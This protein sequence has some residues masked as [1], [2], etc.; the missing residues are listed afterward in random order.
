M[1]IPR[2]R[3]T[4]DSVIAYAI[5]DFAYA[6]KNAAEASDDEDHIATLTYVM[7][8]NEI[9]LTALGTLAFKGNKDITENTNIDIN[10]PIILRAQTAMQLCINQLP[11][12]ELTGGS[13][14]DITENLH[15]RV[16]TC[17]KYWFA[18]FE[19]TMATI[20]PH[21]THTPSVYSPVRP[22]A[23]QHTANIIRELPREL[24]GIAEATL[25]WPFR[26]SMCPENETPSAK[27]HMGFTYHCT[28]ETA[29]ANARIT[30]VAATYGTYNT[31]AAIFEDAIGRDEFDSMDRIIGFISHG[32]CMMCNTKH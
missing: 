13:Q 19:D 29:K 4:H 16:D 27:F 3:I 21:M 2:P 23:H 22:I 25:S 30:A 31:K 14:S 7:Q 17:Y 8:C 20:L 32:I 6:I 1:L 11:R 15:D 12:Q 28:D 10:I 18:T 5:D 26:L 9:L 24:R